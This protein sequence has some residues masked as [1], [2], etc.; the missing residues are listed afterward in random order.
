MTRRYWV[1]TVSYLICL[2]LS[3]LLLSACS[4]TKYVPEGEYLLSSVKIENTEKGSNV[5]TAQ[6]RNYVRQK[7]NARW[8]SLYKLP[9]ATYSLSGAD[10]ARWINR[11]LRAMG[12]APVFF[13]SLAALQT[14]ADM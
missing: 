9:L 6:M 10:T 14:C 5:N 11:T 12:E 8:F 13:D 1:Q 4:T 2:S 3:V 7:P